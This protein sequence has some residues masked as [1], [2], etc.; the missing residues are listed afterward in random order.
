MIRA[1]IVL[2]QEMKRYD[3][4]IEAE[5]DDEKKSEWIEKVKAWRASLLK[6]GSFTGMVLANGYEAELVSN[7]VNV[8]RKKLKY[9]LLYIEDKLVGIENH[10]TIIESWLQDPS[11]DALVLFIHGMGG[12]GKTTISKCIFNS[13][14]HDYHSSCFLANIHETS[15]Q[16]GGLLGLQK[17]LLFTL[18]GEDV[19]WN[20]DEGIV[21]MVGSLKILNLSYSV[22]LIKTPNFDGLPG[23]E[24]LL[25]EGCLSLTQVCESIKYLERLVMLDISGC[26]GL[27]NIP[28]LPRSLVSLE[29]NGCS[30]LVGLGQVQCFDSCALISRLVD[31]N[32]SNCNLFDSSFPEDWSKLL[33]LKSLN[34]SSNHIT[35][36]PGCVKT[37]PSLEE[38]YADNCSRLQSVLDI[39]KSVNYLTLFGNKS[40][41]IVQPTQNPCLLQ[42]HRSEKLCEVEGC[43]KVESIKNVDRKVI[44]YLGLEWVSENAYI[45]EESIKVLYEFGI[46]STWVSGGT[47]PCFQYK[48]MGSRISFKVPSHP[49]GSRISG[50]NACFSA[51]HCASNALEVRN[52]LNEKVFFWNVEVSN[53]T[54]DFV[55]RYVPEIKID[56]EKSDDYIWL[57]L[58]RTGNLLDDGDEIVF[59]CYLLG[60]AVQECCVNLVYDVD[61]DEAVDENKEEIDE[62]KKDTRHC[63]LNNHI[64]WT[65]RLRVEVSDYVD[66][67]KTYRFTTPCVITYPDFDGISDI[68]VDWWGVKSGRPV[69]YIRMC[70]RIVRYADGVDGTSTKPISYVMC[71]PYIG[72]IIDV[73]ESN[74]AFIHSILLMH[75]GC[76]MKCP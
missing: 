21:K 57:S 15:T 72:G 47:L 44:R 14:C 8:I 36:L 45:E 12:V 40:L 74:L 23:L 22:E 27:K 66:S 53:K 59:S 63:M 31:I 26:R 49:S 62:D 60:G 76:L 20:L 6:A 75:T 3:D 11:P 19:I 41:E 56:R 2:E 5:T 61:D 30:S 54:K 18:T 68:T 9:K 48:E 7:I 34:M 10:V 16:H 1:S 13:N 46:F 24:S 28:C 42:V 64:S 35:S 67:G 17:Q 37:L 33:S 58:W 69:K 65:D 43:F 32:V 52:E 73:N 50:L 29:M 38:L 55:W 51:T 4:I 70:F 71:T 39:P 25:L